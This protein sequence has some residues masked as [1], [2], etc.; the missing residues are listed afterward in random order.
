MALGWLALTWT[1]T[2][3]YMSQNVCISWKNQS[4]RTSVTPH[5]RQYYQLY[6]G[7][8]VGRGKSSHISFERDKLENNEIVS[9]KG[10]KVLTR[11]N[12]VFLFHLAAG[13]PT[14]EAY[15]LAGYRG[16]PHAAYQLR[17]DLKTQLQTLLEQGGF[18]R[19]QLGI[20]IN[21]LNQ[22][23]LAEDLKNVNFKQKLDLLR[24][25]D[26]ALPKAIDGARP[27]VTPFIIGINKPESVTINEV[28]Q[29]NKE[30]N[31]D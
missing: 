30:L 20:E 29:D 5:P 15:N 9:Y 18:T 28:P 21:R 8:G 14:L 11:K 1:L 10:D 23:P 31:A 17:S 3:M 27:K 7:E 13:R 2:Q 22:I 6:I 26:K 19:E 25:M 12:K 16:E 24:L 4:I